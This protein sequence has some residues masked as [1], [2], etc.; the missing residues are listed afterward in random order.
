MQPSI[1]GEGRIRVATTA[2]SV[3]N[4]TPYTYKIPF[5]I[6]AS[7]AGTAIEWYDFYL[8]GVLA[9]FFS[10]QFFPSGDSTA[11]LLSSLATFGAGFAVRP[12]GAA[13]FGRIGDIVGRK[14]TFLVTI[15]LM[16]L[17]TAAVGLLPTFAQIGYLAPLLLLTLRLLQGLALGGEY[18][19]AAI[20]VAEH[21]PDNRR[22]SYTSWIQTTATV[23]LLLALTVIGIVRVTMGDAAFKDFGWRLPFLLSAIL[24]VMALYVRLRLRETPLFT[25][26]KDAGKSSTSPWRESFGD[27]KNRRLILLALLGMTAGQ[28]VVWYQG[29]FQALF[30]LQ[31][32][33]Q[34]PFQDSYLITAV[35]IALATPFFVVFGRLSDRIGRKKIILGGCLLAA[36]TY[37]PIYVAM[38]GFA[39]PGTPGADA[40]GK[41]ITLH[42]TPNIPAE[43]ALVFVQVLYVTMVYGPIAAF[44]VEFF[45][46]R[47]RYTSL[48]IPYHIGNGWF[49]G[50]LPLIFTAL[51]TATGNIY[52]GLIYPIAIALMSVIIGGKY[53]RETRQIR[54]WDEVGGET[55]GQGLP[56]SEWQAA[57]TGG[58]LA[59]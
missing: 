3:P 22:G 16:G 2:E 6:A 42:L 38:S 36:I 35:G 28:A 10:T 26:L 31:T 34:I 53:I 18:G 14:F 5:V 39:G 54:I 55:P 27:P 20:F 58:T 52:A 56:E 21:S 40:A 19:G 49:G 11:A 13:V 30:F 48:S 57:P 47:I 9:V 45:P 4:E 23:G 1:R 33:L 8:Y 51:A 41:A 17:S 44:L 25:R 50:F 32:T 24:V 12:F 43:M 29:Q 15:T 46:A 59:G 37:L 7:A